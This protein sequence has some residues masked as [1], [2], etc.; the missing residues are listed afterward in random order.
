MA[1]LPSHLD[2]VQGVVLPRP[3][4]GHVVLDFCNTRAGW[5]GR[6]PAR[7]DWLTS[8]QAFLAWAGYCDLLPDGTVARLADASAA[9]PAEAERV[10]E[11]ALGLRSHLYDVLTDA[12]A[13]GAFRSVAAR[14][15]RALARR[16]LVAVPAGSGMGATWESPC[17]LELPL[18]RIALL[19]GDLLTDTDR[20]AGIR[21]CPGDSCGWVF[22][23]ARGRRRWCSMATCGNRAK[24]RAHAARAQ[25][26]G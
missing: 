8:Y 16:R 14:V 5:V 13:T 18:D 17:E 26:A 6:G 1:P 22:L 2:L 10:H 12:T 19:A 21:L 15:D 25:G 4:G 11:E 7:V 20:R 3:V 9:E 24:V 23:D